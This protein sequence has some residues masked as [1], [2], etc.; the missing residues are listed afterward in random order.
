MVSCAA[1]SLVLVVRSVAVRRQDIVIRFDLENAQRR[2]ELI[3]NRDSLTGAWNRRHLEPAFK[4]LLELCARERAD[5][6][7]C[8]LDIDRFKQINDGKGHEYG[9][10]VLKWVVQ[11]F[12]QVLLPRE[13]LVRMGGDEF[14]LMCIGA[15]PRLR[16]QQAMA[17]LQDLAAL[18][19]GEG[20]ISLSVGFKR[21]AADSGLR[22]EEV[23]RAADRALYVAKE[24]RGTN[25]IVEHEVVLD[26]LPATARGH[27]YP[28][29]PR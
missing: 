20:P 10:Q 21:L 15:D 29:R 14:V 28:W 3:A 1:I 24:A 11:A 13:A 9:D 7:F 5:G 8:V 18:E 22:L 12:H 23:Y 17:H 2:L 26:V 16:L 25:K 27:D 6:Y 19:K 4:T